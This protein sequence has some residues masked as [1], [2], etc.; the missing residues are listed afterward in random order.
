MGTLDNS[1]LERNTHE[2]TLDADYAVSQNKEAKRQIY[3]LE[4]KQKQLDEEMKDSLEDRDKKL[5]SANEKYSKSADKIT[6][7]ALKT[8]ERIRAQKKDAQE[9]LE[10]VEDKAVSTAKQTVKLEKSKNTIGNE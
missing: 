3:D 2:L 7:E 6:A 9:R 8:K 5:Q 10:E 1:I 4:L